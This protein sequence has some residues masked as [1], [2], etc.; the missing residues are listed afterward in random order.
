MIGRARPLVL[1]SH[2]TRRLVVV[3][4]IVALV[5]LFLLPRQTQL[6]LQQVSKPVADLVSDV[7][8][9]LRRTLFPKRHR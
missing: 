2:S 1:W 7:S 5:L 4:V 9:Q 8:C 3:L 6:L